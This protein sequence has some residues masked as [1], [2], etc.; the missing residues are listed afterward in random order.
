MDKDELDKLREQRRKEI[1]ESGDDDYEEQLEDQKKQIWS[2]AAQY[3]TSEAKSRL[4]N[5][6]LANEELAYAVAQQIS[7]LGRSNQI[8]RVDDDKMK[9]ILRSL[10]DEKESGESNIKFRR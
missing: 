5:V 1:Q 3:M 2:Q 6:K 9:K 7:R 4:A 10:Q 8:S